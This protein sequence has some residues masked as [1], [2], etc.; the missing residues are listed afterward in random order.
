MLPIEHRF[1][2]VSEAINQHSNHALVD[3]SLR[4]WVRPSDRHLPSALVKLSLR[5][6][7]STPFIDL[8]ETA[9]TAPRNEI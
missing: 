8:I 5:E 1:A 9:A 3:V 7:V 4:R 2:E 6:L